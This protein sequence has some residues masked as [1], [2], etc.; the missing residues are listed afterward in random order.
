MAPGSLGGLLVMHSWRQ[1]PFLDAAPLRKKC[2][3]FDLWG[4][5][6][7]ESNWRVG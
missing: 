2:A 6:I 7:E 3:D 1:I 4:E 5:R